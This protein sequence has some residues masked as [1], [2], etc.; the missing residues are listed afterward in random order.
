MINVT[1]FNYVHHNDFSALI[2]HETV[3]TAERPVNN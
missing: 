1:R 3:K 2:L